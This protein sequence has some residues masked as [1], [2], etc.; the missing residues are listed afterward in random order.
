MIMDCVALVKQEDNVLGSDRLSVRPSVCALTI[1]GAR[2][3]RVQQRAKKGRYQYKEFVCV[4]N[5]LHT[6]TI[7]LDW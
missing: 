4:S 7:T 5:Y 1:L 2:L 3:C 6:H